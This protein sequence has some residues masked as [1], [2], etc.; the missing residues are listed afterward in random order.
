MRPES[1]YPETCALVLSTPQ[2]AILGEAVLGARGRGVKDKR[3]SSNYIIKITTDAL[4]GHIDLPGQ[5]L[6]DRYPIPFASSCLTCVKKYDYS[7]AG[8]QLYIVVSHTCSG[9]KRAAL[10]S[11]KPGNLRGHVSESV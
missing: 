7:F 9:N 5:R 10:F 2:Y 3:R 4:H 8:D 1:V 11:D 6:R